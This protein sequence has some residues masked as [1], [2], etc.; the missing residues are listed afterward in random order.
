[1]DEEEKEDEK[2]KDWEEERGIVCIWLQMIMKYSNENIISL[3]FT[4]VF[5]L[6]V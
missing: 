5:E 6:W 2:K 1:M 4:S 3:W